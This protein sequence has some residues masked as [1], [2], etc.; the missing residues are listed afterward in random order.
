MGS[1][2]PVGQNVEEF[3][4]GLA[5]IQTQLNPIGQ[6]VALEPNRTRRITPAPKSVIIKSPDILLRTSV[7]KSSFKSVGRTPGDDDSPPPTIVLIVVIPAL[8]FR[9]F[10][11]PASTISIPPSLSLAQERGI[12]KLAALGRPPSPPPPPCGDVLLPTAVEITP[13]A[14]SILRKTFEPISGI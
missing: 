11:F 12:C 14:R 9:I 10:P 6:G 8:I 5:M 13:L 2:D 3:K 1:V 4:Q 7:E